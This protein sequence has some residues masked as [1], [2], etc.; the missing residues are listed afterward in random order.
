[1]IKTR[2]SRT[3]LSVIDV[4]DQDLSQGYN[5]ASGKHLCKLN[6][7]PQERPSSK[8]VHCVQYN[9]QLNTLLQQVC[10]NLSNQNVL[11]IPQHEDITVQHVMP[12]FLSRKQ[13]AK[14]KTIEQL[15][16]SDVKL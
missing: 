5:Q 11:G 6:F 8:K 14:D 13:K 16:S 9:T 2:Y 1:M 15:T 10:D 3:Y 4:F 12:C 7:A